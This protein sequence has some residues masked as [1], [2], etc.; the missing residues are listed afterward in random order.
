MVVRS[1][2]NRGVVLQLLS[3]RGLLTLHT[4][5]PGFLSPLPLQGGT[6]CEIDR[7][8]KRDEQSKAGGDHP[9]NASRGNVRIGWRCNTPRLAPAQHTFAAHI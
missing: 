3:E 4:L 8:E 2:A 9:W 6:T 5:Q 7:G 1:N